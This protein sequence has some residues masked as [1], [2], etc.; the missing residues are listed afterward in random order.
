MSFGLG[1][2]REL[3]D[4]PGVIGVSELELP[5][6]PDEAM[7]NPEAGRVDPRLWFPD[8]T[9]PLEIEVGCGKGTFILEQARREPLV[10]FL[11]IEWAREFY[12]YAA[13]RVRRAG[14]TNVRMLRTDAAEFL[15]W[16]CPDAVARVIHL[17]FSDPWP[18]KKHHKNRV[19]QDRF[20][21]DVWRVLEPNGQTH[22]SAVG[23]LRVVTDHDDLWEWDLEHFKRWTNLVEPA[24]GWKCPKGT[25]PFEF[26]EFVPPA[27]VGEG[28]LVG[29]NYER[30]MC[31]GKDPHAGVMRKRG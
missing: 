27:W 24:P 26:V 5:I 12:L 23:E 19:V 25:P 31:V 30:K 29:T 6:L 3:D 16:R 20:L 2:G 13:D 11:G 4:A 9:R 28:E 8:P 22:N 14:L 1:H 21:G 18:K 7:T 15:R 10:N 17:Y